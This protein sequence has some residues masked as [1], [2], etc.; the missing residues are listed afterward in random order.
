MIAATVHG[1]DTI[2]AWAEEWLRRLNEDEVARRAEVNASHRAEFG[3]D[4]YPT[5]SQYATFT[6]DRPGRKFTRVVMTTEHGD[7]SVHAFFDHNTGDVLK[8]AGWSAPAKGA[9][10]NLLDAESRERMFARMSWTSGYL[11]AGRG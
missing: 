5:G 6:L 10:F 4:L 2:V 11:Y 9:R 8:D 7:R 1:N 3:R